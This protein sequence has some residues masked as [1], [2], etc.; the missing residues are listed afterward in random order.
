MGLFELLAL[1]GVAVL[2]AIGVAAVVF[3][4]GRTSRNDS[5]THGGGYDDSGSASSGD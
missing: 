3:L 2:V 1:G 4:T 5:S